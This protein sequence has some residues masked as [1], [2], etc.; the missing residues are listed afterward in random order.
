MFAK[1]KNKGKKDETLRSGGRTQKSDNEKSNLIPY[2][3]Y[4]KMSL[5]KG[6]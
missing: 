6:F 3:G 2:K 5:T 4:Q 1:R